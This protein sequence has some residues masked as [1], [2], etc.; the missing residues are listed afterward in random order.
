[1]DANGR[2][3]LLEFDE[4]S[5]LR[6][7]R[8]RGGEAKPV[9]VLVD[10]ASREIPCPECAQ[11]MTQTAM[12]GLG[13]WCPPICDGCAA[14]RERNLIEDASRSLMRDREATIKAEIPPLYRLLADTIARGELPTDNPRWPRI[15]WEATLGSWYPADE[16]SGLPGVMLGRGLRL[17]GHS[18]HF[19][20]T[21]AAFLLAR[22][23]RALGWSICYLA[24]ADFGKLV[25]QEAAGDTAGIKSQAAD[26]LAHARTCGLLLLDDLGTQPA[27]PTVDRALKKLLE[28]R[29]G[30][31]RPTI[32]TTQYSEEELRAMLTKADADTG[33]A[34]VRRLEDYTQ[35]VVCTGS[36]I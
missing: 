26:R 12:A 2:E 13:L 35:A 36:G 34:I 23:H 8:P 24:A 31:L 6:P 11:P 3:S 20:S 28:D 10:G 22:T 14:A 33:A 27:T 18:G 30:K 9:A 32:V 29:T 17:F 19:K 15:A 4:E 21:I 1:M 7:L 16:S 25:Q 5:E